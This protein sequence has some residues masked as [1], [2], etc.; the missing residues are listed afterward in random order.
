MNRTRSFR[1][2]TAL[3]WPWAWILL[4]I[5]LFAVSAQELP[6]CERPKLA[7]EQETKLAL[8]RLIQGYIR[9]EKA[10]YDSVLRDVNLI[11]SDDFS[12]EIVEE[13]VTEAFNDQVQYADRLVREMLETV[14][15]PDCMS[16]EFDASTNDFDVNEASSVLQKCKL[17]VIR[18]VFDKEFLEEYKAN[19]TGFI[20]GLRNGEISTEGTTSNSENYFLQQLDYGRWEVLLPENLA[21]PKVINNRNVMKVLAS[22]RVLGPDL[23]V[24]SLGTV[25]ADAGA[26]IQDW[27]TDRWVNVIAKTK[28][29]TPNAAAL[30]LVRYLTVIICS[31]IICSKWRASLNIS[32][33]PMP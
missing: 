18:N 13:A 1:R 9:S 28:K 14:N 27:H 26:E 21:H 8:H 4:S 24:H 32:S 11:I 7:D 23:A 5:Q 25:L 2:G 33:R 19:V 20:Q 17:L 31:A 10:S 16:R 29:V 30:T 6:T 15:D 12:P 3:S 22:E